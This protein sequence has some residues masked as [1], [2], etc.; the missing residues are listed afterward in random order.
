[1]HRARA[2]LIVRPIDVDGSL[3]DI[4][5][6]PPYTAVYALLRRGGVPVGHAIIPIQRGTC[7]AE[8]QRDAI[9]AARL[10]TPADVPTPAVWPTLSVIV[11]TRDRAEGLARCL[12]A[13]ERMPYP[14]S[15]ELLV[16]D[17]ASSTDATRRA[18]EGRDGVRYIR[19]ERPGLD[20]AR[21]RGAVESQG[22]IIAFTDDDVIVDPSWA[23]AIGTA[24]ADDPSIG[25]LTG[26]V[27]PVELETEAQL[28]FERYGGFARG[29]VRQRH[30]ADPRRRSIAWLDADVGRLGTGANMAF[31]RS[32]LA[33]VGP[34]DPA[35]D[36]G[37]VSNGGGDL[38]MFFRIIKEGETLLYE[39][40][41]V[42][43]HRHRRTSAELTRQITDWGLGLH[44]FF[45]SSVRRYP[46]ERLGIAALAAALFFVWLSVRAVRAA[47][48]RRYPLRLVAGEAWG[49]VAAF[50]RYPAARRDAADIAR[51]FGSAGWLTGTTPAEPAV[52]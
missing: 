17:N 20:W 46:E 5:A 37:T 24:F 22:E 7:T 44:A 45:L 34:F 32:V 9:A 48:F 36:V 1:M 21:N 35:L 23:R 41:A 30:R 10:A 25:A 39:P 33:R 42:V 38:E 49:R 29:Y 52:R 47:V 16:V 28:T 3:A 14:G 43:W 27:A 15:I 50:A 26:L 40:A 31:R 51:R 8:R 6:P 18:C 2:P 12:D 13:L 19:E 4:S 11:C